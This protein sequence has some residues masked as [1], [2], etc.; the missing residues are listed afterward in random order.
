VTPSDR[1]TEQIQVE[2]NTIRPSF[3]QDIREVGPSVS[4][5]DLSISPPGDIQVEEPTWTPPW[6]I[7]RVGET[8]R[9]YF[10]DKVGESVGYLLLFIG[11]VIGV[12]VGGLLAFNSG[13]LLC[14]LLPLGGAAIIASSVYNNTGQCT[15]LFTPGQSIRLRRN[16]FGLAIETPL[17]EADLA[18]LGLDSRGAGIH[19]L[20]ILVERGQR[21]SPGLVLCP[22]L[23]DVQARR[24]MEIIRGLRSGELQ[25]PEKKEPDRN[26]ERESQPITPNWFLVVGA[27]LVMMVLAWVLLVA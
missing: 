12:V 17:T 24:L 11:S 5:Q 20:V 22:G 16:V 21:R 4:L 26:V 7:E 8:T 10:P 13:T 14:L 9:L 1:H 6:V 3:A 23:I 25:V 19:D 18:N 15:L 27:L 2:A